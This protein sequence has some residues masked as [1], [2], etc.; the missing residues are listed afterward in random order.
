MCYFFIFQ[1]YKKQFT[2]LAILI[3]KSFISIFWLAHASLSRS[4]FGD[5]RGSPIDATVLRD[6]FVMTFSTKMT[7]SGAPEVALVAINWSSLLSEIS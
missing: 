4:W 2:F 1:E 6:V 7:A 3:I 5:H